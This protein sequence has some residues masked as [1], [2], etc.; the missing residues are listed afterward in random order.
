MDNSD[1]WYQD[2]NNTQGSANSVRDAHRL[3][4]AY[5]MASATPSTHV[6]R[7]LN[8]FATTAAPPSFVQPAYYVPYPPGPPP[9]YT[10][11]APEL[12]YLASSSASADDSGY[13]ESS[14]DTAVT[15]IN[16]QAGPSYPYPSETHW[17]PSVNQP[18]TYSTGAFAHSIF[19]RTTPTAAYPTPPPP[20]ISSSSSSL[21]FALGRP[22]AQP[23]PSPSKVYT[24]DESTAFVNDFITR[25]TE[26]LK[27]EEAPPRP[28]T[29]PRK[30]ELSPQ[31]SPDP[32][33]LRTTT[34]SLIHSHVTPQK[35]KPV[36]EISS[37]PFKRMSIESLRTKS[38]IDSKGRSRSTTSLTATP[39][40][41]RPSIPPTPSTISGYNTP[42]RRPYVA[43]PPNPWM[44]PTTMGKQ[45]KVVED[46]SPYELGGFGSE[47]DTLPSSP[48]KSATRGNRDD[49]APLDKLA[50][51]LSDIFEAEDSIPVDVDL[52]DLDDRYWSHSTIDCSRPQLHPNMIRK[53]SKY[54]GYVSRPTK[55]VR[56][57]VTG[58][59][60][61]SRI[62]QVE[63]AS[64]SR[65]MKVLERSVK[66]GEDVDPFVWAHLAPPSARKNLS[67][68]KQART[69]KRSKSK[70]P[71]EADEEATEGQDDMVVDKREPSSVDFEK[72]A[73]QI[74]HNR[75]AILAAE[76][77]ITLLGSDRLPKQLYS[78]ELITSCLQTVKNQLNQVIYPFVEATPETANPLL[79][80]V[81]KDQN[82]NKIMQE[83]FQTL[84][85]AMPRI[86]SL[87]N[88]ESVSMSD[89]II[90]S[91][92][93]IA[94][95]PFFVVEAGGEEGRGKNKG[96]E[97]V[98]IRTFGKS[99]MRGLR[100]DALTLI[101]SIFASH[102]EQRSWIIEEIL[103]SLIKLS[104]S[105][106]KA[107]QFKLRDGRSIR[108]VSALLLQ[109]VQTSAHDV[110]ISAKKIENDR[111]QK[112]ALRRQES[113]NESQVIKSEPFMDEHDSEEVSLYSSGLESATK[114]AKA[115]ILFLTRRS[116]T[117]KATKNSNEAEYRQIFDNLLQDVLVVLYWPEWPA[118]SLL[119]SVASKFMVAA[120]DDVKDSKDGQAD[121]NA[122]KTIALDHLGVIA[123]K[124][125][126]SV[127]NVQSITHKS[128][129]LKPLDEIV[130]RVDT[131]EFEKLLT[132]YHEVSSHLAKRSTE[133]PAYDSAQELTA[134]TF[135]NEL[136]LGI[137]T[138]ATTM[139]SDEG[140]STSRA[141]EPF[142]HKLKSALRSVGKDPQSDVFDV[143]SK[144]E[145]AKIDR[146]AEEVGTIQNLRHSFNPILNVVLVSLDASAIFMRTKALKALGQIV[147]SDPTILAQQAVRRGIEGH[148]LDNSAA[149]RDAAVELIGKYMIDSPEV[150]SGYFTKIADRI[151]D[152]GLAVRKRVIKLLKAY[153]AVTQDVAQ[154]A[155]I[156]TRL[157]LRM[158]DEDE[159]VKDL[160]IKTIEEL[161]FPSSAPVPSAMKG[162]SRDQDDKST[163]LTKVT[164]IMSVSGNFKDRQSPLEDVLHTIIAKDDSQNVSALHSRYSEICEV[165]I[166]GLVDA[167]DLPGFT[168]INCIKTIYLFAAAYPA[169]LSGS[170]ASTLLPY[171]KNP[172]NAEEQIQTDYLLKIFRAAIP[173]MPRTNTKFGGELQTALQPMIIKPSSGGI[174]VL[175]ESVATLCSVVQ[176][177]TKDF[178]RLV[179]LLKSC[180]A[181]LQ[182]A[183]KKPASQALGAN[184]V[185]GLVMLVFIVSLLGEHFAFDTLRK[186][187]EAMAKELNTITEG[188]V[189]EHIYRS[190]LVLYEKYSD[191]QLR[192]RILQCLGFLFRAQPTLMTLEESARI[193]DD[194][195]GSTDVETR[196]RLL[197][198]LQDFLISEAIKHSTKEKESI[199]KSA[200]PTTVNMD[201]LIGNTDGFADSG[202][203]SAVVQ[204]YLDHILQAALSNQQQIQ[205]A[206][207]DILSFTIKQG[208]AHPLQSFPILIALETSPSSALSNRATA[209]HAVLHSKHMSLINTRYLHSAKAAFDYQATLVAG[210]SVRGLRM[211]GTPIALLQQWYSLIR[212]KRPARQE[213]LKALLKVFQECSSAQ[214]SQ[215]DVN[216][217]RFLSDN[218]SAFDYKTQEEVFIV[219]KAITSFL[220][221][222]GTLVLETVSPS[223]LLSH[224]K[225][226]DAMDVDEPKPEVPLAERLPTM[227][228]TIVVGIAMLLKSYLK[229]LYSLSEDKC[230]KFVIGKKSAVGDKAVV[231]KHQN[232]IAWDRLPFA[233]RPMLTSEDADAQK[234]TFLDIWNE[235]GQLAE[236]EDP[237]DLP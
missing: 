98:V 84:S 193:M 50:A 54:I 127:L 100:L 80:H 155:E 128:K 227:R 59:P 145:M 136:A 144:E 44:T 45:K 56:Q 103:L 160:A 87:V 223:H 94:I 21:A 31:D 86:N 130:G 228:T 232:A 138:I 49:R 194:I 81:M 122:I 159:S 135:G 131:K 236:P 28:T 171:L 121:N 184:D 186:D 141:L 51:L 148:L 109:L 201:E 90:I 64:L 203:S 65:I 192:G 119:L 115:I 53:L 210:E 22:A 13:W 173:H 35:R 19:Q 183:V 96:N 224:I 174:Q 129:L 62:G 33:A 63:T 78:E 182:Q 220:S 195:F 72:V 147:V 125:R 5:P 234:N 133:D 7:H 52:T 134:A 151:A 217:S 18:S 161:W 99:A 181:R 104:D 111:L 77:C 105:K 112:F 24:P 61:K 114:A 157:V 106:Q 11:Y 6:A 199:K 164:V 188:S 3:L 93:Y 207:V 231:R 142:G 110:R 42:R 235:D 218:L 163:L 205:G 113:M 10:E 116:G 225:P 66:L 149:V 215:Q 16:E 150:A 211:Q 175:Q 58:S 179:F 178:T 46:D 230:N 169:V 27:V 189:I 154:Q 85:A 37:S 108:T 132:V 70:T 76:C 71:G 120:L 190:L 168:V 83:I 101:R 20:P 143:G 153:Y 229:Q 156:G 92:V 75:A 177:L 200:K 25:K 233:S 34:P 187:N 38:L 170:N 23:P 89:S 204:R 185:K 140:S 214:C 36:V 73:L 60:R 124:I 167:S 222:T 47:D 14:R 137:K 30:R 139:S 165:L 29:P 2:P 226:T 26:Q 216:F 40:S 213:Y 1:Q 237:T 48:L 17:S 209:L 32:L 176:H 198:I 41:S 74:E 172:T 4:G 82:C 126:T 8:G 202:V 118:A 88:A 206:A 43:V 180:N 191:A 39:T 97:N 221:T 95:G 162:R 166:D 15:L 102:E 69:R 197:R 68:K 79:A 208:L 212:D 12:S 55:R 146:H 67:P 117:G 91:A 57:G 9:R 152:T 196:G 107:G 219:I 158:F 123:A